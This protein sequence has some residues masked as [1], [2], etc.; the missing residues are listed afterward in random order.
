MRLRV[1]PKLFQYG[2]FFIPTYGV[3][4]ALAFLRPGIQTRAW[5]GLLLIALGSGWLL[6]AHEDEPDR[7]GSPLGIN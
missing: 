2:N 6:L 7:S 4:V 3:L 1:Y 5:L